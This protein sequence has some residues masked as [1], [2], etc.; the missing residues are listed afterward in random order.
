MLDD[1]Q[2][3]QTNTVQDLDIKKES[4]T[5][6][7]IEAEKTRDS[8]DEYIDADEELV[9]KRIVLE[10]ATPDINT[11]RPQ[12]LHDDTT[13]S[14][15]TDGNRHTHIDCTNGQ[16]TSN[17]LH[18]IDTT[19]DGLHSTDTTTST[20]DGGTNEDQTHEPVILLPASNE[21]HEN[22]P[23][24]ED[25]TDNA[26]TTYL[27]RVENGSQ[28]GNDTQTG[29]NNNESLGPL[30]S[31]NEASN[32]GGIPRDSISISTSL[33]VSVNSV[34]SLEDLTPT[35]LS[36]SAQPLVDTTPFESP[37][38]LYARTDY[39]NTSTPRN[40]D[41]TPPPES[42]DDVLLLES[43]IEESVIT[44]DSDS[45]D[46]GTEDEEASGDNDEGPLVSYHIHVP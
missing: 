14:S 28:D 26:A 24:C 1:E 25:G 37:G 22:D 30:N 27:P 15:D 36:P 19:S 18:S 10:A 8:D 12:T 16:S 3:E 7:I 45:E 32:D 9:E 41:H 38:L 13:T 31:T 5:H 46:R 2:M 23:L 44:N 40:K 34:Q 4:H 6:N 20:V 35:S 29:L 33:Q 11:A 42:A 39:E 17:G 43:V 21:P